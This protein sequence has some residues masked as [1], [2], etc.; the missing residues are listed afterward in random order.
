MRS[1]S[2]P[3]ELLARIRLHLKVKQLQD[4]LLEKNASL[5]RLSTIDALTG[6]RTRRYVHDLL[7][8]EFLRAR[9]YA[10]GIGVAEYRPDFEEPAVL[11]AAAHRALCVAKQKGRDRV[12]VDAG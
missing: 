8:V 10:T 2:T 6:L 9:R 11:V 5:A 3:L 12:E 7:S 1:R 4:E